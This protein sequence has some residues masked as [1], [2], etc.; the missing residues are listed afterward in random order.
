MTPAD[1]FLPDLFFVRPAVRLPVFAAR[2]ARLAA[3]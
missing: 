1:H 3:T 2:F